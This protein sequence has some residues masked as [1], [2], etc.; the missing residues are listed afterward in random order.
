[1]MVDGYYYTLEYFETLT[2]AMTYFL[3]FSLNDVDVASRLAHGYFAML[4]DDRGLLS[5]KPT[6]K[7]IDRC[8]HQAVCDVAKMKDAFKSS[9]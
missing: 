7:D 8:V 1:M 3:D 2:K 9:L 6:F 5:Y 4:W